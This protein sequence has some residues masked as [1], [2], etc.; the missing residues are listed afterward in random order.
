MTMKTKQIATFIFLLLIV[1]GCDKKNDT[2]IKSIY[3]LY[4]N[5]SFERVNS[6]DCDEIK[7]KLP[8]FKKDE[9]YMQTALNRLGVLE[10]TIK[11][12]KLL[13]EI[14]DEIVKLQP[15]TSFDYID[16]RI[17]CFIKYIDGREDRLCIGGYFAN[18]IFYNGQCQIQNNKLLFLIKNAVKYY[19]W[20]DGEKYLKYQDELND[21]SIIRDSVEDG[22]GKKYE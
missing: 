3:V 6:V 9:S 8:S 17:S 7:K 18:D 5:Y 20:M 22:S 1:C 4:Y 10:K 15:D 16:A 19:S 14:E 2:N 13:K 21:K 12:K 11:N